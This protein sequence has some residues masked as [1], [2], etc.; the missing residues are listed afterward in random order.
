MANVSERI[1]LN[2]GREYGMQIDS[3]QGSGTKVTLTIPAQ[4]A[5]ENR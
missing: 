3:T 4:W 5:G 2:F 1:R